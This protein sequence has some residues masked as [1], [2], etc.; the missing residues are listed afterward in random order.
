MDEDRPEMGRGVRNATQTDRAGGSGGRHSNPRDGDRN[1]GSEDW[2]RKLHWLEKTRVLARV[3]MWGVGTIRVGTLHELLRKSLLKVEYSCIH[4]IRNVFQRDQQRRFDVY[5]A[6]E[7]TQKIMAAM[8][9]IDEQW[10]MR[11]HIPY[12]LREKS[13]QERMA[14]RRS[15][16]RNMTAMTW[17]ASWIGGKIDYVTMLLDRTS[18]DIIALQETWKR[19]DTSPLRLGAYTGVERAADPMCEGSNGLAILVSKRSGLQLIERKSDLRRASPY[20]LTAKIAGIGAGQKE[21]YIICIY[22]PGSGE[23]RR[24]ALRD[25][26]ESVEEIRWESNGKAGIIILGDWNMKPEA[27]QKVIRKHWREAYRAE[28]PPQA[29]TWW[30]RGLKP[31]QIDHIVQIGLRPPTNCWVNDEWDASDHYPVTAR[32]KR[33]SHQEGLMAPSQTPRIAPKRVRT[34]A[35]AIAND[36]RW[37]PLL[38]LQEDQLDDAAQGFHQTAW[39]VCREK[40]ATQDIGE[41]RRKRW[42]KGI[43]KAAKKRVEAYK[44]AKKSLSPESIE[45]YSQARKEC[46]KELKQWRKAQYVRERAEYGEA[47]RNA[48][49]KSAWDW[50]KRKYGGRRGGGMS[51]IVDHRSKSLVMEP[52][53]VAQVWAHWFGQLARDTTGHSRDPEHWTDK[54]VTWREEIPQL[55]ESLEWAEVRRMIARI[56]AGKACGKDGIPGELLKLVARE[57]AEPTSPMAKAILH[58]AQLCWEAERFPR[59][60]D[61]AVVVPIPKKGD[62]TL[63]DNY[64]GISLIAT[65]QKL[66]S[67]IIADRLMRHVVGSGRISRAQAGFRT[68][69]EAVAQAACLYEILRRRSIEGRETWL[70]FVDFCKAYDK[71]PHEALMRKVEAIGVRGRMLRIIRALYRS[72]SLCTR[73]NGGKF[74]QSVPLLCG[75]RQGDPASPILFNIFVDDLIDPEMLE[76]GIVR[77]DEKIAGLMFADDVVLMAPTPHKLQAQLD[78]LTEWAEKWEFRVNIDKC[79]I[80]RIRGCDEEKLQ[81]QSEGQVERDAANRRIDQEWGKEGEGELSLFTIQGGKVP[82]SQSYPYLGVEMTP[83]LDLSIIA[84]KRCLKTRGHIAEMTPF[85]KDW[86]IPLSAKRM[87][88]TSCLMPRILYG[89]ELWGMCKQRGESA[90]RIINNAIRMATGTSGSAPISVIGEDLKILPVYVAGACRKMRLFLKAKRTR[91]FLSCVVKEPFMARKKTWYTGTVAWVKRWPVLQSASSE[92]DARAE[93]SGGDAWIKARVKKVRETLLV[94]VAQKDKSLTRTTLIDMPGGSQRLT[95]CNCKKNCPNCC[96][97]SRS[98]SA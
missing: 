42:S 58:L 64:R 16:M 40:G 3:C 31:S 63:T 62:L 14:G 61:D 13:S 7:Q 39:E 28:L 85:L 95:G 96:G 75:V 10:H 90:Q 54:E 22:I 5:V 26:V 44:Q 77:G 15:D 4:L 83:Q 45:V 97:V 48:D 67:A 98:Y 25:M 52:D 93:A 65:T 12:Q 88:I 72:P 81:P 9:K 71:V 87:V 56:A 17:N 36:N 21:T 37:L 73:A 6:P 24:N 74:S 92:A 89:A 59:A 43:W 57:E 33:G 35:N 47:V 69:E 82:W 50:I 29:K 49:P 84:K 60:W 23:A 91:T 86:R 1:E 66:M 55:N 2:Y 38:E 11:P 51:P 68:R 34:Q 79:A 53:E 76:N 8:G 41:G 80:M 94:H 19:A 78:K 46:E 32:W 20:C 70:C 27:V 30:R 18:P